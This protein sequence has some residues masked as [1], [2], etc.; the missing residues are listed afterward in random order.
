M[1]ADPLDRAFTALADR[2]RRG[3]IELLRERPRRAG[4]L[5]EALDVSP[6]ALTRHLRVLREGLLVEE[7]VADDDGRARVYRLKQEALA[8][9]RRW[10]DE[11][12]AM[13]QEQLEAFAAHAGEQ[14]KKR[15]SKQA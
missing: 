5:A 10:V 1:A 14:G 15:R 13:W 7:L 12:E 2:T 9:L 4:E 8:P 3:V 6:P 11:V